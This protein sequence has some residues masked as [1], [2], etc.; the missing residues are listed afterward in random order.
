M[1]SIYEIKIDLLI[2]KVV[3]FETG[4]PIGKLL[5][6]QNLGKMVPDSGLWQKMPSEA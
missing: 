3:R 5:K 2:S 6:I 4:K 1:I